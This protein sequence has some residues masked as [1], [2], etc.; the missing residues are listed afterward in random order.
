[1]KLRRTLAIVALLGLMGI[2]AGSADAQRHRSRV[3]GTVGISVGPV[4]I[5]AR[6]GSPRYSR[7]QRV[8]R[9]TSCCGVI[10]KA[11]YW[12]VEQVPVW[13]P[14]YYKTVHV[15]ARY[16][17]RYDSCGNPYRILVEPACTRRVW[18]EGHH[19]YQNRRVWVKPTVVYR[20]GY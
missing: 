1:M 8:H 18:V 11:G 6:V 4:K 3:Q 10:R 2:A 14:G 5:N 9:H 7:I 15:P 12:K 20:C 19:R 16:E 13:T 17:T